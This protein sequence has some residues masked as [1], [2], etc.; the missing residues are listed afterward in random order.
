VNRLLRRVPGYKQASEQAIM[1]TTKAPSGP[2]LGSAGGPAADA[3]GLVRRALKGALGTLARSTSDPY[4]SLVTVATSIS[5]APLLLIS[6]LALHTQNLLANPRASLLIDGTNRTGDPLAGGRVT[7]I[8]RAA[9]TANP[10]DR[11]RFLA[12]HPEAQMYADFPDFAFYELHIETAH[13]IGGFGRIVDLNPDDLLL[14]IEQAQP[15]I[16][17][18]QDIVSHMNTDHADA[19]NLFATRLANAPAGHWHMTGLDPEGIDLVCDGQAARI[20]FANKVLSA[21]AARQEFVRMAA[22]SRALAASAKDASA[23]AT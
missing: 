6:K 19:L 10:D 1:T 16:A 13:F 22:D 2:P 7:V 18:Q 4:V 20:L 21:N 14:N 12:R 8:G 3:R 15:L 23:G 17:A 11:H 9:I 5:G